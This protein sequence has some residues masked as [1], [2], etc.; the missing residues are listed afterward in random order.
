M[1]SETPLMRTEELPVINF[2]GGD[3]KAEDGGEW[4]WTSKN[5]REA[6]E[7]YGC[8]IAVYDRVSSEL[9]GE[10]FK[11]LKALFDLPVETKKKNKYEKPFNGYVGQLR[12]LPLHESLGIDDATN[13]HG[14]QSFANLMWPSGNH[15]FRSLLFFFFLSYFLYVIF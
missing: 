6:L 9:R 3:L 1:G 5:V 12:T 10:I 11:A 13:F 2:S 14:V 4:R 8:F 7:E 15:H